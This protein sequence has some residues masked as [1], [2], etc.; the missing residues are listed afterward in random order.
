MRV[1]RPRI[2]CSRYAHC[3]L[4][5]GHYATSAVVH[6]AQNTVFHHQTESEIA[7]VSRKLRFFNFCFIFP[8]I[9][10]SPERPRLRFKHTGERCF[11]KVCCFTSECL[12]FHNPLAYQKNESAC[13]PRNR[14]DFYGSRDIALK[15]IFI[16]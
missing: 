7:R 12:T 4:H 1:P 16:N 15:S 11:H 2:P 8:R 6:P 13:G 10:S 3:R 9:T 14:H 5:L